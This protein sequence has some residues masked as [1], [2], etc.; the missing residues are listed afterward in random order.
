[1]GDKVH[2]LVFGEGDSIVEVG[3]AYAHEGRA[4]QAATEIE[5]DRG[6]SSTDK[7]ADVETVPMIQAKG[8]GGFR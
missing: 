6:W 7:W 5:C 4:Q 8:T 2:I 1:M 3:R